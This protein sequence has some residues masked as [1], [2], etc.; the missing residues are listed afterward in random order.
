M[1]RGFAAREGCG[2]MIECSAI[3]W[4][5][6][7]CRVAGGAAG[8]V[9]VHSLASLSECDSSLPRSVLKVQQDE[10]QSYLAEQIMGTSLKLLP[11][12]TTRS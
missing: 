5:P 10:H 3:E 8:H 1:M 4:L 9:T 11:S 12:C 2:H 6:G 7:Q